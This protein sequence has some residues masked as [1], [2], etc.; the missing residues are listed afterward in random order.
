MLNRIRMFAAALTAWDWIPTLC[1][2]LVP[3]LVIR[4]R[5]TVVAGD[6]TRLWGD[7]FV[8]DIRSWWKAACAVGIALAPPLSITQSVTS[9]TMYTAH[10]FGVLYKLGSFICV[11]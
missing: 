1:F 5:W 3:A 11:L 9:L 6:A 2:A 7:Y 10:V 4:G 8:G